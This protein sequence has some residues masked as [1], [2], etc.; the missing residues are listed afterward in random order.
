MHDN[1]SSPLARGPHDAGA[2][3]A[4]ISPDTSSIPQDSKPDIPV[5]CLVANMTHSR[6]AGQ[7][8]AE[9]KRGSKH[10]PPGA[11]LYFRHMMGWEDP[12]D[13]P[14]VEVVGRHRG[15]H[16]YV[17]MIV[18]GAWL[19]HWH[20]DLVYSPYVAKE[21]QPFWDGTPA[22]KAKAEEYVELFTRSKA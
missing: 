3:G 4:E 19:E 11:K 18:R 5:W 15:S 17:R 13:L 20:A 22:S 1:T 14:R 16:R 8:G 9:T 12:A 21:L 10:F 7:G 2:A 6:P